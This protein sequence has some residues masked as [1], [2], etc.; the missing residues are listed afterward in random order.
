MSH[1]TGRGT[2]LEG[3]DEAREA[4]RTA[5]WVLDAADPAD[6]TLLVL[7]PARDGVISGNYNFWDR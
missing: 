6:P 1:Q 3:D 2:L 7:P 4:I 5:G